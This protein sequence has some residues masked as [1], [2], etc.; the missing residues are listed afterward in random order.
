MRSRTRTTQWD[1]GRR[2][3]NGGRLDGFR[4][5]PNDDY[6]IG[7][8]ERGRHARSSRPSLTA[9]TLYDRYFCSLLGPTW[10]NREYMHSAQSGG[11][12]TNASAADVIAALNQGGLY[13]WETI[14]DLMMA[15]GH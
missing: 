14:W 12:K 1:G 13:R 15:A 3:F 11:N 6:A 10:P 8:Y 4:R 9:F 7:Y 2:Q 5:S